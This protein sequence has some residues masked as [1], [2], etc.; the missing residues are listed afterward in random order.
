[1]AKAVV[2]VPQTMSYVLKRAPTFEVYKDDNDLFKIGS[3]TFTQVYIDGTKYKETRVLRQLLT[4]S[5]TDDN[6]IT[7]QAKETY[8]HILV[9]SNAHRYN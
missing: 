1:M 4:K 5:R 9:Q 3:S 8:K 7:L 6:I 2:L